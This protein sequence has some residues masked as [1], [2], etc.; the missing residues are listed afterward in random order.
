[1]LMA[2]VVSLISVG[3]D[4]ERALSQSSVESS[5]AS[6]HILV[7]FK[8]GTPAESIARIEALNGTDTEEVLPLGGVRVVDLPAGLTVTEAIELYETIPGVEFAEPDYFLFPAQT[9]QTTDGGCNTTSEPQTADNNYEAGPCDPVEPLIE[10]PAPA[11]PAPDPAI[12]A[13]E[14]ELAPL[15]PDDPG[16]PKQWSLDNT[17]QAVNED[18]GELR[19]RRM[20]T[21]THPRLEV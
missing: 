11:D 14:P 3:H 17:G 12:T 19:V 1:M 13:P 21:W 20:P 7:K 9:T 18:E 5:Y 2:V 4:P 8:E 6:D 15:K 16:Y 10:D